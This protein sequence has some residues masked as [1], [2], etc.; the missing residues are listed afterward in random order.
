MFA[1]GDI[2]CRTN[3][4]K[5]PAFYIPFDDGTFPYPANF[6]IRHDAMLDVV[7]CAGDR[8]IPSL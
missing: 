6:S 7:R 2:L 8:F 3:A 4:E 1:G 5:R